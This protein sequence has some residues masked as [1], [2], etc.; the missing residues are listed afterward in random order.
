MT[1]LEMLQLVSPSLPVGAFS[2]SE[3]LEWLVQTGK[4]SNESDLSNWLQA[5]LLRGQLRI[6]AAAQTPI[7]EA[8]KTWKASKSPKAKICVTDWN[9]WLL[10]LRDSSEI[11][12][13]QVQMGRSLMQ[14]LDELGHPLPD[15]SKDFSWPVA[16]GWAGLEWRL[17]KLEV[18]EAY[19]YSWV[20]NQLSAAVR[21]IPLG[22]TKAQAVQGNLLPLITKQAELLLDKDPRNLWTGDVGSTFAQLSHAELYSRLFRS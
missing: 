12:L 4:I 2:Y 3:G 5:E 16:W 1:A 8:L 19:L 15:R 18:I 7:R 20:A 9:C 22:P 11:R 6:E 14:S 21:L 17:S 13:Q 10:A